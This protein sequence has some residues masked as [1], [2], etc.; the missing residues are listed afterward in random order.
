MLDVFSFSVEY[1]S[2]KSFTSLL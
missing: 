1:K 2:I